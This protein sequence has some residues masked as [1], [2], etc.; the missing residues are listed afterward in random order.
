ML[1]LFLWLCL[2]QGFV[3]ASQKCDPFHPP[4]PYDVLNP[5]IGIE[6]EPGGRGCPAGMARVE[7]FCIDRFEASLMEGQGDAGLRYWSPYHNPGT[8]RMRAVSLAGAVPQGYISGSQ[9]KQACEHSGKRLCGDAEWLRAC[10]GPQN[11]R[12]PFG[13]NRYP[14]GSNAGDPPCNEA[15]EKHPALELFPKDPHPFTH[16]EN[17][18]INQL[19]K[20]VA[21]SGT[22]SKCVSAEGIYDLMGNLHEW[23]LGPRSVFR[24]GYYVDTR[25]NGNGCGYVTKAHKFKYWDYSTGF[26]CCADLAAVISY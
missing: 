25:I 8:R 4:G 22:F 3:Q 5:N 18:C 21:R 7:N 11:T 12:Y 15:R 26:R 16:L 1:Y 17:P 24:G 2:G 14:V 13:Q 9:A 20:S 23:T 10:R 19:E 6:E